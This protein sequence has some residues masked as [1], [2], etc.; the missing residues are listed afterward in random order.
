MKLKIKFHKIN[1]KNV[2]SLSTTRERTKIG[3]LKAI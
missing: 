1:D 2:Y 3:I